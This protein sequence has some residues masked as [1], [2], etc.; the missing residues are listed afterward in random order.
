MLDLLLIVRSCI[1]SAGGQRE[2]QEVR[3]TSGH[4][5]SFVLSSVFGSADAERPG[6]YLDL[7]DL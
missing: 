2:V 5:E 3:K 6:D 7:V 4:I 1:E